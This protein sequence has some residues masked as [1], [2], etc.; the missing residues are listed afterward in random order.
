MGV[1]YERISRWERAQGK[2]IMPPVEHCRFCKTELKGFFCHGCGKPKAHPRITIKRLLLQIPYTAFDL[3]KG[4]LRT[5]IDL[6][7]RPGVVID[8]YLYGDRLRYLNPI[9]YWLIS[10]T[11]QFVILFSWLPGERI[12]GNNSDI[13]Y[14]QLIANL[15][16]L[17][18]ISGFAL[19]VNLTLQYTRHFLGE[20][21]I[22]C[23]FILGHVGLLNLPVQAL[24]LYTPMVGMDSFV[25]VSIAVFLAYWV[26]SF[27][28]AF[29]IS[30]L[31]SAYTTLYTGLILGIVG[32]I[33]WLLVK[34]LEV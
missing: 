16:A 7:V 30:L 26:F 1:L 33:F 13:E 12:L 19:V 11:L 23:F 6:S 5:L 8:E 21:I 18:I 34:N 25:W 9:R 10:L 2:P 31:E 20:T 32:L 17:P 3:E 24:L 29:H 15:M 22:Y 27:A 14:Y 28:R 4:F